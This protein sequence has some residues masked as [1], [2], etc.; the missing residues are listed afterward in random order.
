M[1]YNQDNANEYYEEEDFPS[2]LP[3]KNHIARLEV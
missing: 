3:V 2:K 1:A